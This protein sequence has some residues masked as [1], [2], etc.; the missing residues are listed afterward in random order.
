MLVR[1]IGRPVTLWGEYLGDKKAVGNIAAFHCYIMDE[2]G[3][4]AC[5]ALFQRQAFRSKLLCL[6]ARFRRRGTYGQD[7][8]CC[9]GRMPVAFS[10]H[11]EAVRR[12]FLEHV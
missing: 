4:G 10:R 11:I 2:A 5:S 12:Q 7:T 3:V 9:G 6:A 1:W 8:I